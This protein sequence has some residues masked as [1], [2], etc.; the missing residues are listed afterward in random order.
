LGTLTGYVNAHNAEVQAP[1]LCLLLST[2]SLGMWVPRL[3]WCWTLL[4]GG[5]VPASQAFALVFQLPVPYTNDTH[6]VLAALPVLLPAAIGVACGA[7]LGTSTRH[8]RDVP[9]M[10]D[11]RGHAAR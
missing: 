8:G 6:H 2:F 11:N 5:A 9:A 7:A 4:L 10:G 1:L 3:A